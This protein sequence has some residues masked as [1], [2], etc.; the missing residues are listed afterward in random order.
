MHFRVRF[1]YLKRVDASL[2]LNQINVFHKWMSRCRIN[3]QSHKF[4]LLQD[5]YV[6]LAF[7]D[8]WWKFC[9]CFVRLMYMMIFN[10]Y[11]FKISYS[12]IFQQIAYKTLFFLK[13]NI[14]MLQIILLC[15]FVA[16]K[17]FFSIWLQRIM[18]MYMII[19]P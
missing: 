6:R 15:N 4:E 13:K 5:N 18:S 19:F 10:K 14:L 1:C 11:V 2:V 9:N 17:K 12:Q 16:R 8:N 3:P 7:I